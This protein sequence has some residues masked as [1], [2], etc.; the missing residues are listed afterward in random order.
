MF[1]I[2]LARRKPDCGFKFFNRFVRPALPGLRCLQFGMSDRFSYVDVKDSVR[3]AFG[4]VIVLVANGEI[5]LACGR[6]E[7][8]Q[9]LD[10]L[11]QPGRLRV[12]RH[13]DRP[14]LKRV[15]VPWSR[16]NYKE[17]FFAPADNTRRR[18]RTFP[19]RVSVWQQVPK[20]LHRVFRCSEPFQFLDMPL[21]PHQQ[22]TSSGPSHNS[23]TVASAEFE[24][25]ALR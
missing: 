25:T 5:G 4:L 12:G 16:R 14:V 21:H 22:R 9:F 7:S 2:R 1:P 8:D 10:R 17:T 6:S 24:W 19:I 11:F 3:P 20:V 15:H 18:P 13:P 23:P